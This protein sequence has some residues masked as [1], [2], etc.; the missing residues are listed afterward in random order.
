MNIFPADADLSP[1]KRVKFGID[2]TSPRLHFIPLRFVKK[3]KE[4]GHQI[5]I[6]IGT[7]TAQLGDPSGRDTTRPILSEDEVSK[8][9]ESI[10]LK[11]QE[12]L[13]DDVDFFPNTW[14]HNSMTLPKFLRNI[15]SKF[16]L[17]HMTSRNAFADRIENNHPIA[18]HELLVPM[19]QGMDS[20]HLK[21]EIEIGGQD[22][23]FNFQIARQLQESHGQK[24]QACVMVPVINGTDGRKM[25]K[26]FGNCIFLDESANDIF[27][28]VMSIPDNVMF[29]WFPLLTDFGTGLDFKHPMVAKKSLAFEIV[30]QVKNSDAAEEAQEFF[31][32]TIQNK[33]LPDNIREIQCS[34]LIQAVQDIRRCSKTAARTLIAGNGVKIDSIV[35]REEHT[36][37]S[38]GQV[39]QVGKRDFAKIL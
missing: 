5:T 28:K 15:A 34:T 19:L 20:V 10:I 8:N 27:G 17:S 16:T 21:T 9:G 4:A 1:S 39:V 12:L 36:P 32:K 25:S 6:V 14:I 3:M 24:P 11:V 33:E 22:Q 23:L 35:C 2:P 26:S 31:E 37:L 30:K 29:E 7:F 18:M 38:H 13:G